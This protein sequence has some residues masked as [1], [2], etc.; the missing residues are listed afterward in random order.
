ML[1]DLISQRIGH[2]ETQ[3]KIT[4]RGLKILQERY[5]V[6]FLCSS[7]YLMVE[8]YFRNVKI[9]KWCTKPLDNNT[10]DDAN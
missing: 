3:M 10:K 1:L 2:N 4:L 5:M 7:N 9:N 6:I 8:K